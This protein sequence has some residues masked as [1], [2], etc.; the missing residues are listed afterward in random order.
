[1]CLATWNLGDSKAAAQWA[2]KAWSYEPENERLCNNLK[3]CINNL[4]ELDLV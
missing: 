2:A 1:M 4:S 3:I